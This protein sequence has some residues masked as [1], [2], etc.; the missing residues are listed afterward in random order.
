MVRGKGR[1]TTQASGRSSQLQRE[2]RV[3][4]EQLVPVDQFQL[5]KILNVKR[6]INNY[7]KIHRKSLDSTWQSHFSE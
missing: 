6:H 5:N 7:Q 3:S 2:S 1:A 4:Q